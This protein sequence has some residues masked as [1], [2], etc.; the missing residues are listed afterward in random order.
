MKSKMK[1]LAALLTA[2]MVSLASAKAQDKPASTT[3][4]LFADPVIARGTGVEI[5][6]SRM[7]EAIASVKAGAMSRNE[8]ISPADLPLLQKKVLDDLLMNQLLNA[9][10][11]VADKAKGKEEGDKRFELT[12][13]RALNEEALVKQLKALGLTLDVLHTRLIEEATAEMVMRSQV[14]VTDD[15][16]KKYYDDHPG[17]FEQPEMARVTHILLLT[18]DPRSGAPLSEDEKKTKRKLADELLKR[19]KGGEDFSKLAREYS[20]DSNA[21]LNGG[22]TTFARSSA[23]LEFASAAFSLKTNQISDVVTT[24]I[25]YHIIKLSEKIPARKEELTPKLS[26]D[27]KDYLVRQEIEKKARDYYKSLRKE[28]KVEIL[29]PH[30]KAMVD[31]DDSSNLPPVSPAAK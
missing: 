16:V 28:A 10:A 30:L 6:Q 29:D 12:K 26:T 21:K 11:T 9:K 24:S 23:P 22:E 18:T 27:I 3:E 17:D 25:G 31:E 5:K 1:I 13:K 7:D 19:A 8:T 14:T 2:T 15:Q 20:E 4:N